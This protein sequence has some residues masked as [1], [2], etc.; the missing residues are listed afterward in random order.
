MKILFTLFF[1]FYKNTTSA[2]EQ[3]FEQP[4]NDNLYQT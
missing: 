2:Y 3:I 4:P 1:P